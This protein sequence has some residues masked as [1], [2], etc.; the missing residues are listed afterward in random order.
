[1]VAVEMSPMI[2][3]ASLQA[4]YILSIS[5]RLRASSALSSIILCCNQNT[6]MRSIYQVFTL[7]H[8]EAKHLDRNSL[9][10][11]QT[12]ADRYFKLGQKFLS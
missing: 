8:I 11:A 6:I 1:M 5:S 2:F 10:S 7:R 12:K 9:P 4:W 3:S